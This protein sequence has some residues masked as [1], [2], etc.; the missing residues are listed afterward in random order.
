MLISALSERM[1]VVF[2]APSMRRSAE[3]CTSKSFLLGILAAE[4]N[5]EEHYVILE[6]IYAR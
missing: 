5:M 4:L 1:G 6:C 2:L 3:F